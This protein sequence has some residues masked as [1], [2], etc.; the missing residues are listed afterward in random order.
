LTMNY[1]LSR[2]VDKVIALI[3][4]FLFQPTSLASDYRLKPHNAFLNYETLR[5]TNYGEVIGFTDE[6]TGSFVWKGIPFARPPLGE[7]RWRAP[8]PPEP[9]SKIRKTQV[10]GSACTQSNG[11]TYLG[12]EDCLYLNVWSPQLSNDEIRQ[13]DNRLPV[14]VWIHGGGNIRGDSDAVDAGQLAASQKVIVVAPNYR[15]GHF[16]WL[17]HSALRNDGTSP[18]DQSGNYGTL[19]IIQALQWVQGNIS[20]FGGDPNRV[21]VFGVSAGARN[22][23]SLLVSPRAKGLF[24]GAIIQSG[25][26]IMSRRSLAENFIDNDDPGHPQS[27]GELLLQLLQDDGLFK[28]REEAKNSLKDMSR[29]MIAS[30]LRSKAYGQLDTAY[31]ALANEHRSQYFLSEQLH[32]YKL[33]G[34]RSV[35]KLFEDG[36]VLSNGSF[37]ELLKKGIYHK[38][39][40]IIGSNRDEDKSYLSHDPEFVSYVSGKREIKN[41]R[42]YDS[43]AK[44]IVGL[45]QAATVDELAE[46]MCKSRGCQ[47]FS[48]RFDWDELG[49]VGGEDLSGLLGAAH[50]IEVPFV[51]GNRIQQNNS[52]APG[53]GELDARLLSESIMSYWAQFAYTGDPGGGRKG[54]LPK[55][56][57]FKHGKKI[58]EKLVLDVPADGGIRMAHN[59]LNKKQVLK[60]LVT[61]PDLDSLETRCRLYQDIIRQPITRLR[62]SE[63]GHLENGECGEMYPLSGFL[64]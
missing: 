30:Y 38:L 43:T 62:P 48:Y 15:L 42:L 36:F 12:N 33:D 63:Y 56:R 34:T 1:L 20:S 57:S 32:R 47:I 26:T 35:P 7:L 11:E 29:V 28:N 44:Y 13:K 50:G 4:F 59:F 45:R 3:L 40:V 5:D 22:T 16:G 9:W 61:D 14:M 37:Q 55:W 23:A 10:A 21:T 25:G 19:D 60:Q 41:K 6:I 39:P 49:T 18:D 53:F 58:G 51:F 31:I 8:Q 54:E 64:E 17:S 24:Q 2:K 27:S 52:Y 46:I